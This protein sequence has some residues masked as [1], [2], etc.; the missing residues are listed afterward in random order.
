MPLPTYRGVGL[1]DLLYTIVVFWGLSQ[2]SV[3]SALVIT[4]TGFALLVVVSDWRR[5]RRLRSRHVNTLTAD[6]VLVG[7]TTLILTLW[8]A[9]L[10]TGS[11]ASFF[12]LFAFVFFLQAVRDILL[13]ELS[14]VELYLQGQVTLVVLCA[15]FWA[16]A[17]S[18][19]EFGVVLVWAAILVFVAQRLYYLVGQV[20]QQFVANDR[21]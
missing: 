7:F 16:V 17:D 11:L 9:A 3:E 6:I 8:V 10:V 21:L 18:F 13:I 1:P 20:L 2:I 15:V 14:L 4:A 12:A 5:V 19:G